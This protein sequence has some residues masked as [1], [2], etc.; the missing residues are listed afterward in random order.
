M[1]DYKLDQESAKPK[2]KISK[3]CLIPIYI[4]YY[5]IFFLKMGKIILLLDYSFI[6]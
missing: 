4:L 2:L 1:I 6:T 3:L 5:D